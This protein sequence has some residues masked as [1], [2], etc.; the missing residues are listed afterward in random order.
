VSRIF[1]VKRVS[2]LLSFLGGLFGL[3]I[4]AAAHAQTPPPLR[5][6]LEPQLI[7]EVADQ[8]LPMTLEQPAEPTDLVGQRLTLTE[9]LYC[10]TDANGDGLM[11]GVV[12]EG[13][14]ALRARSL[15]S[16][17]CTQPLAAI[18]ARELQVSSAPEWVEAAHIRLT[19]LPWHLTL[20]VIDTASA[21]RPGFTPPNL[22]SASQGLTFPTSG[23]QPLT[24]PGQNLKFD[25]ALGFRH[26]GIVIDAYPRGSAT[27]PSASFPSDAALDGQIQSIPSSA[28]VITAARYDFINQM[29]TLYSPD[30]SVPVN[31][32]GFSTTV[33]A[34]D[35]SISGSNNQATLTGKVIS[36]N[37]AYNARVDCAGNDLAVQ[38]V[39]MDAAGVNC[40]QPD[41]MSWLQCQAG[42]GLAAALTAYYQNQP[43]HVSTQARPLHFDFGGTDYEA[44]FTALKTSSQVGVL[45]EAGQATL[46]RAG[47]Q[48][49]LPH[50]PGN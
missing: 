38:Q 49:P 21:A 45:S 50:N 4:T 3:L 20:V 24:G 34:R 28:N 29:L 12:D 46:Q 22:P 9:L 7:T 2:P 16:S 40:A 26:G 32:Q 41:M 11:V 25:L 17:D 13:P 19:W 18:A 14:G 1:Q 48:A 10:G 37:L 5:V 27:N 39:A 23:L 44:Y 6:I 31:V 35:L 33:V 15:T 42:H 47:G 30:F 36:Q 8:T 43:L